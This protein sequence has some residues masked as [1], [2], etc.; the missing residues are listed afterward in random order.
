MNGWEQIENFF[1]I[2][3]KSVAFDLTVEDSNMTGCILMQ[4]N[5]I[6]I[7]RLPVQKSASIKCNFANIHKLYK[8]A[9][10]VLNCTEMHQNATIAPRCTNA[11]QHLKTMSFNWVALQGVTTQFVK[12]HQ[13]WMQCIIIWSQ[14]FPFVR[15][16]NDV[17]S[18]GL[19]VSRQVSWNPLCTASKGKGDL[20][21][22]KHLPPHSINKT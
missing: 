21:I 2:F 17:F 19:K 1:S 22:V 18:K 6:V 9:T 5:Y 16:P 13:N 11:M 10:I 3:P 15:N 12:M 7:Q 4:S 8:N 20:T 14:C